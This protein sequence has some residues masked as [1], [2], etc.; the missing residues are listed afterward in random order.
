MIKKIDF[1]NRIRKD[2]YDKRR[3]HTFS[4][5]FEG[6][7]W[8]AIHEMDLDNSM[9]D[10]NHLYSDF[11]NTLN[12]NMRKKFQQFL[13]KFWD[14]LRDDMDLDEEIEEEVEEV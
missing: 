9:G 7:F 6:D 8:L 12:G 2:N 5:D 13:Q 4:D 14:D 11:L 10:Y 3:K 1:K